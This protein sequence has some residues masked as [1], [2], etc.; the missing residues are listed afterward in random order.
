MDGVNC[1]SMLTT[2]VMRKRGQANGE[3]DLQKAMK[4]ACKFLREELFNASHCDVLVSYG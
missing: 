1:V 4:H 2:R 3:R